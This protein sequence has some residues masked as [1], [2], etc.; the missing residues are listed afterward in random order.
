MNAKFM[1]QDRNAFEEA[2]TNRLGQVQP[3]RMSRWTARSLRTCHHCFP[4]QQ[5]TALVKGRVDEFTIVNLD[6]LVGG[7]TLE[8][9]N[10]FQGTD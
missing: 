5:R 10:I 3:L 1:A 9:K 8:G 4:C 7:N 2:S 6:D